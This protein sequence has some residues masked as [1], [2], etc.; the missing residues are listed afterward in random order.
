MSIPKRFVAMLKEAFSQEFMKNSI[1]RWLLVGTVFLNA[2]N[3]ALLAIFIRPVNFNIILHYNVYFGVDLIG[4]WW[5]TYTLPSMGIVFLLINFFLALQFYRNKERIASY[6]LL[7]ASFMIQIG[8]II[9]SVGIV[10]INY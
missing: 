3:W 2:A 4:G 1:I 7:L 6:I 8:L 5:Q 10:L 9:A